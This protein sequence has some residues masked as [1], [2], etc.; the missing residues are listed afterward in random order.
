MNAKKLILN[1]LLAA[2][3]LLPSTASYAAINS[4]AQTSFV[5]NAATTPAAVVKPSVPNQQGT[6]Q[7]T[8]QISSQAGSAQS[9]LPQTNEQASWGLTLLGSGLLIGLAGLSF[10]SRLGQHKLN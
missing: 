2:A 7:G 4:Q 5:P 3:L 10:K 9:V 8:G 6:N 1:L